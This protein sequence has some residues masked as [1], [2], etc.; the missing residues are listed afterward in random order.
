[1]LISRSITKRLKEAYAHKEP[2]PFCGYDHINI[3]G[4]PD[5]ESGA[6]I[7]GYTGIVLSHLKTSPLVFAGLEDLARADA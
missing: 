2:W 6:K 4:K 1:M 3:N 7:V 5:Y